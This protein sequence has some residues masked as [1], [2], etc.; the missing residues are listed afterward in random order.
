M[1][2]PLRK[3]RRQIAYWIMTLITMVI[4]WMMI[5]GDIG[6]LEQALAM[7]VVPS[8]VTGVVAFI[9]GETY[10]DHSERRHVGDKDA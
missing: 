2:Q 4:V 3:T 6:Q 9:T 8:L 1:T 5:P 7:V 10:S